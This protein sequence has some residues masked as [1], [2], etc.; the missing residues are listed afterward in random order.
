M[1]DLS[2][3]EGRRAAWADELDSDRYE[4]YTGGALRLRYQNIDTDDPTMKPQCCCLGVGCELV[5]KHAPELLGRAAYASKYSYQHPNLDPDLQQQVS[6]MP[7]EAYDW[8]GLPGGNPTATLDQAFIEAFEALQLERSE[9]GE[10]PILLTNPHT[11]RAT[12]QLL[13]G[14]SLELA[15]MNDAKVPFTLIAG[16]I[17]RECLDHVQTGVPAAIRV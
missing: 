10:E 2:T 13:E 9:A 6:F 17:R 7:K 16:L 3:Y 8:L 12:N 4:Q 5:I 1:T 15:G 14:M 11:D